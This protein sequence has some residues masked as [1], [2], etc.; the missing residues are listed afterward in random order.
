[1]VNPGN[2]S[3]LTLLFFLQTTR[4]R[5]RK[6]F[7]LYMSLLGGVLSA[8]YCSPFTIEHGMTIVPLSLATFH[9]SFGALCLEV[10]QLRLFW[11][12]YFAMISGSLQ[13]PTIAVFLAGG[14]SLV[15]CS[16]LFSD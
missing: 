13:I 4:L 2:P 6:K 14:L 1:M 10:N 5:F 12:P 7:P 16:S 15:R 9:Q 3:T 11:A 8:A